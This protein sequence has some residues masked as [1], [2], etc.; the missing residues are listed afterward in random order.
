MGYRPPTICL[1]LQK[2]HFQASSMGVAKF[3]SKFIETGSLARKP[4]S[5]QPSKIPIKMKAIVEAR[6][7]DDDETTAYQLG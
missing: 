5:G 6:M 1:L 3:I 2:E 7:R 4:G